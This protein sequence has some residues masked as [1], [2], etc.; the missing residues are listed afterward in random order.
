MKQTLLSSLI[1]FC[2]FSC[3]ENADEESIINSLCD[4]VSYR[5]T[6]VNESGKPVDSLKLC[7]SNYE[8]TLDFYKS[9]D[10]L[11]QLV[12]GLVY[13]SIFKIEGEKFAILV[14]ITTKVY[15]FIGKRFEKIQHIN[16]GIGPTEITKNKIDINSDSHPDILVEI[17]SG[18]T[19]GSDC[20]FLFYNPKLRTL[21]YDKNSEMRNCEMDLKA[22]K[23]KCNYNWSSALFSVEKYSFRKLETYKYLRFVSDNPKLENMFERTIFDFKGKVAKLDTIELK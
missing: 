12:V 7:E 16:C 23:V 17:P 6:R 15:K 18:G 21:E 3:S 11:N 1:L 4:K 2:L 20:I 10:S 13:I 22:K 14:D 8:S 19:H 9:E 5:Y